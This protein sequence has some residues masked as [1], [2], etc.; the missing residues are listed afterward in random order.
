MLYIENRNILAHLKIFFYVKKY[1]IIFIII[2]LFTIL[3]SL[4]ILI[5]FNILNNRDSLSFRKLH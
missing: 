2:L 4:S 5:S 3:I 1:N